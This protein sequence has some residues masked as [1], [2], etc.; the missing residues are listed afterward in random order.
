[1]SKFEKIVQIIQSQNYMEFK[2]LL[3][4]DFI[5]IQES[6]LVTRDDFSQ[7]VKSLMASDGGLKFFDFKCCYED[8]YALIWQDL[9]YDPKDGKKYLVTNFDAYKD[10]L[11]WRTMLNPI[12]VG[13]DREK[14]LG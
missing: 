1:M 6:G 13:N 8:E 5:C 12:T 2:A 10:N 4:D 7:H 3:H 11:L 9:F 14:I